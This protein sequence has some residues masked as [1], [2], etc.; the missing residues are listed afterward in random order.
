MAISHLLLR[1]AL[2][3]LLWLPASL[4]VAVTPLPHPDLDLWD[5]GEVY[6]IAP[7]GNGGYF[8]GGVFT[9][10]AGQP[11][12]NIARILANGSLDPGFAPVLNNSV[13]TLAVLDDGTVVVGGTFTTVNGQE[14]R[15]IARIGADGVL[16]PG[17]NPGHDGRVERVL[18]DGANH[19]YV[20]GSFTQMGGQPRA[21]LA[22]L[23]PATG[24]ADPVW[25]PS[26]SGGS[27]LALRLASDGKLWVGGSFTGMNGVTANRAVRLNAAGGNDLVLNVNSWVYQIQVDALDRTYLCGAFNAVNGSTRFQVARITAAGVSEVFGP[28]VNNRPVFDCELDGNALYIAGAFNLLGGSTRHGVAKISDDGVL[29]TAFAP[30]TRGRWMGYENSESYNWAVKAIAPG[31][32]AIGGNLHYVNAQPRAGL[33][34]LDSGDG[35]LMPPVD[36]E[37]PAYVQPA[38]LRY[39]DGWLVGGFFRRAGTHLR[40]NLL[41]LSADGTLDTDWALPVNGRVSSAI[42]TANGA[43]YFGGYFSRVGSATRMMLAKLDDASVPAVST[44]WTPGT[45]GAIN[46]MYNDP[47]MPNS[48]VYV[49]GVFSAINGG[50]TRSRLARLSLTDSGT[51]DG[52]NP[53]IGNGEVHAIAQTAV[54]FNLYVGGSFTQVQGAAR[55]RLAVFD[56]GFAATLNTGI[57]PDFNGTVWRLIANPGVS[58]SIFVGGDFTQIGISERERLARLDAGTVTAWNPGADARVTAL[59]AD[60]EG[61]VYAGGF[62]TTLGGQP[63]GS[64]GRIDGDSGSV[65]PT[66]TPDTD[67]SPR[68]LPAALWVDPDGLRVAGNFTSIGGETRHALALLSLEG[69]TPPPD[70]DIFANGF[71]S[72]AMAAAKLA[73]T[74]FDA[75]CPQRPGGGLPE[76]DARLP[77]TTMPCQRPAQP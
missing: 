62:F 36:V 34:L 56:T 42:A 25:A 73:P 15:G 66:Y 9:H 47:L 74:T 75:V 26:A 23:N 53:N 6:D 38:V 2:P 21:S 20:G 5:A 55:N 24:A 16:D 48:R 39:A 77:D 44:T 4:A 46:V 65:D 60:A 57:A 71:E 29:D 14:R 70:D 72:A 37:T 40:E 28:G 1:L 76:H 58:E 8:I 12:G 7:D 32:I 30:P 50:T 31:R 67:V 3:L 22:R 27:V 13:L 59:A 17:W 52:W 19:L 69:T 33:A 41:R 11:R 49:G 63:S 35:T 45:N 43:A 18:F 68:R 51:P 61:T 10:V 54:S 64:I